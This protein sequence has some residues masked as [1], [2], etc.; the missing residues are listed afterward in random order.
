MKNVTNDI[1]FTIWKMPG[2]KSHS[3]KCLA[4]KEQ[5]IFIKQYNVH[6]YLYKNVKYGYYE[7]FGVHELGMI[8]P[9][10]G[11]ARNLDII[12]KI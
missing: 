5:Y 9:L 10:T 4:N 1:P 6:N 11:T 12:R 7:C 3:G 8:I 2:Y